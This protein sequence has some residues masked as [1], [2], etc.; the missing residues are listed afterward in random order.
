MKK[1]IAVIMVLIMTLTFSTAALA[2]DTVS[3]S[4]G[5]NLYIS[6]GDTQKGWGGDGVDDT[7]SGIPFAIFAAATGLVVRVN[8]TPTGAGI[9]FIHQHDGD[10]WNWN[11]TNLNVADVF[12]ANE[13]GEGGTFRFSFAAMDG[14]NGMGGFRSA[15]QGKIMLGY[16]DDNIADLGIVSAS[17]IGVPKALADDLGVASTGVVTFIGIA[18]LVLAASGTGAVVVSR[19]LKK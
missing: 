10:G 18:A 19:K 3:V 1:A 14:G 12:T 4:L 9:Q 13:E 2:S 16:Y 17:L 6:N 7:S 5:A 8:K 11:Q 15:S